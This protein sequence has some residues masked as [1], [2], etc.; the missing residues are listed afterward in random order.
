MPAL[1]GWLLG[2]ALGC[3]GGASTTASDVSDAD[4]DTDV[5]AD[6][7]VDTDTDTDWTPADLAGCTAEVRTDEG[8]DE[9]VEIT[10]TLLYDARGLVMEQLSDDPDEPARLET[11]HDDLGRIVEWRLDHDGDQ[12]FD[13]V[14]TRTLGDAQISDGLDGGIGDVTSF[15]R[16]T[17]ADGICDFEERMSHDADTGLRSL[18]ELDVDGD[19]AFD[20]T[21]T[22]DYDD[23]DRR[24]AFECTDLL[25][26]SAQYTY[27]TGP[28][29]YVVAVDLGDDGTVD[30]RSERHY[31]AQ[32]RLVFTAED[33]DADG[34][35]DSDAA[36][37]FRPD[38]TI[39]LVEGNVRQPATGRFREEYTYDADGYTAEALFG[40]DV[41]G[42]G[43]PDTRT[44]RTWSWSCP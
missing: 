38:G 36:T 21:C 5:D 12:I 23:R 17:D 43:V 1:A 27:G 37:T 20:G 31:D 18:Y 39:E 30:N 7:D 11:D 26:R 40:L 15:C 14:W 16:D 10:R 33:L 8:D 13:E 6:T 28:L 19:G 34:V 42:D 25:I 29:D 44:R 22:Y 3:L 32:E 4:T 35:W 9:S 41:T 24:V 2:G